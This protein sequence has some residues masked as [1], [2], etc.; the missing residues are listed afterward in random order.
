MIFI[1]GFVTG[2]GTMFERTCRTNKKGPEIYSTC[3]YGFSYMFKGKLKN[4]TRERCL[5]GDVKVV[6]DDYPCYGF[7]Q[8]SET[9]YQVFI[10]LLDSLPKAS[11]KFRTNDEI[12]LVPKNRTLAP[13]ACYKR[14]TNY[15]EGDNKAEY[16]RGWCGTCNPKAKKN[17][18][19][20]FIYNLFKLRF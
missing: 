4:N 10:L 8:K 5:S 19:S 2:W 20:G 12:V 13:R 7:N 17:S 1:Q 6:R 16:S 3:A 9:N 14:E 11:L 15:Y 18:K